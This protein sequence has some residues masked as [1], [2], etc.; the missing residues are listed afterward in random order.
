MLRSGL[1]HCGPQCEVPG[2]FAL[3]LL[4]RALWGCRP[5]EAPLLECAG[6]LYLEA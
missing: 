3:V 1:E 5:G 4:G 6:R 2:S